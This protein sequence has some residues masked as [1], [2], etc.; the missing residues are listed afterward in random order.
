MIHIIGIFRILLLFS[1]NETIVFPN[2]ENVDICQI[3]FY[4][5]GFQTSI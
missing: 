4:L 3:A 5:L 2:T 1:D